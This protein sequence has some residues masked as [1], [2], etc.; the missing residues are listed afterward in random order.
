MAMFAR[1]LRAPR[2]FVLPAPPTCA[3]GWLIPRLTLLLLRQN[4][5][6]GAGPSGAALGHRERRFCGFLRSAP[7]AF[8]DEP[9]VQCGVT[10]GQ[11]SVRAY[12]AAPQLGTRVTSNGKTT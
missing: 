8:L 12:E 6:E 1:R 3:C 2:G 4:H 10:S 5:E 7:P 11:E 9:P